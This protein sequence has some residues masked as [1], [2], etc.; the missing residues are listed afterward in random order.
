MD[1]NIII[2]GD[3]IIEM[4]KFPDKSIDFIC[5]DLPYGVL[6]RQNKTAV[7]DKVIPLDILWQEYERI[8]KDNGAIALFGQGMFTANLMMSNPK[9]WRYNLIWD[10]VNR[11]TGFLDANRKPLR[12]H[13]DIC[14]FYK[15]QPIYNPQFTYGNTSHKRGNSGNAAGKAKNGCYGYFKQTETTITNRKYPTSI[16]R[17]EKE[18]SN[19]LHS[20]QKPVEL[21]AWLIRTYTKEGDIVLDNTAGSMTTAIAA[22]ETNRRYICIEKDDNIFKVGAARVEKFILSAVKPAG[23]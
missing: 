9:M 18:H 3:C 22:M 10:K 7:W 14:I 6:N 13:E 16:I 20:T 8:I 1:T 11:P 17:I 5:C 2:H 15:S 4:Q 21:I 19:F 12:I 23:L